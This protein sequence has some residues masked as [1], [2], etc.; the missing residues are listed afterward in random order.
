ML[1]THKTL[2]SAR[3]GLPRRGDAVA[4]DS[5]LDECVRRALGYAR[6]MRIIAHGDARG[7]R[8]GGVG[9]LYALQASNRL[10]RA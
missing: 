7:A 6:R 5:H 10:S 8:R 3:R 2:R 9:A 4:E 1:E